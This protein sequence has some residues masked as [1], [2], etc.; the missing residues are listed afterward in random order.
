M[1]I[2]VAQDYFPR[3]W[4]LSD[5]SE[6]WRF[7]GHIAPILDVAVTRDGKTVVTAS[8][9]GTVRIWLTDNGAVRQTLREHGEYINNVDFG[10]DD[11]EGYTVADDGLAIRWDLETGEPELT[12]SEHQPYVTG[13]DYDPTSQLVLTSNIPAELLLWNPATQAT[14]Q[15]LDTFHTGWITNVAIAADGTRA[16][17]VDN[18]GGVAFWNLSDGTLINGALFDGLFMRD[19]DINSDQT[20]A[21]VTTSQG[22]VLLFDMATQTEIRRWS[23]G[24]NLRGWSVQFLPTSNQVVIGQSDNNITLYDST[25]GTLLGTFT[26]HTGSINDIDTNDAGTLVVSGSEDRSLRL[27]DIATGTELRR[28]D[29]NANVTSVALNSTSTQALVAN[30]V[31]LLVDIQP[32]TA[33]ELMEWTSANRYVPDFTCIQ[34]RFYRLDVSACDS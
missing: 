14:V 25:T 32:L 29:L 15:V 28:L 34:R 6:L 5:G 7:A 26:G 11:S 21:V 2:S 18:D 27:W 20:Q 33:T 16:V 8:A 31:A 9:D 22:T 13:L 30:A 23:I 4:S 1:L 3:V 10:A 17:S 24:A 19:V 12:F